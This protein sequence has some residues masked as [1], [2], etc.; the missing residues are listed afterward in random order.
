MAQGP[1]QNGGSGGS[2]K[3][4]ALAD[5]TSIE[6]RMV[7]IETALIRA[8]RAVCVAEPGGGAV[9]ISEAMAKAS[10][11][12]VPGCGHGLGRGFSLT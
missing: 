6:S 3:A 7:V 11:A 5:S 1:E 8:Y 12:A 4:N 9:A 10:M 2:S